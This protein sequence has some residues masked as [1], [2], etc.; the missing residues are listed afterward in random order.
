MAY[1]DFGS[2]A[3]ILVL[4]LVAAHVLGHVFMRLHQPRVI[5]EITAGI[6][7]GPYILGNLAPALSHAIFVPGGSHDAVLEFLSMLGLLLLM[8]LSGVEARNLFSRHD[9]REIAW[10]A[11]VGTS[12]P[13]LLALVAAPYIPLEHVAGHNGKG[14][15]LVL[16]FG[17]AV[18]VTSIPVLSRIFHDLGVLHTR[19]ARLVLG[20][21]VIEDILLW[22]VLSIAT[23]LATSAALSERELV[24][25]VGAT[26][27]YF[28]FGLT[29]AVPLLQRLGAARWNVLAAASPVGYVTAV[30]LAYAAVAAVFDVSFVFAAFL[31]G[32]AMADQ[33]SRFGEA[34][35]AL[36][37]LSF[38]VFIPI[39]FAM[40][41]YQLHLG[42]GFSATL[43][44]VF[45]LGTCTV[46]L[47]SVGLGARLAGFAGMDIVNLAV[48]TNARG[49]PGIVLASVA[50]DAGIINGAFYTTLV[51]VALLTSQVAG[52]W[53]AFVLRRGWPLLTPRPAETAEPVVAPTDIAADPR[54][55]ERPPS[56]PF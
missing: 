52:A 23:A 48:A 46:K 14:S 35:D 43:L 36:R 19:F 55:G 7:L 2:L 5:G 44:V 53:L 12:L 25:H 11:S 34:L 40:V 24:V 38:A 20:M 56:R 39:Y 4:L 13:F 49:G 9:R 31:A 21:A 22:A 33:G 17:I 32:F 54:P 6:L 1:R 3:L 10:L 28:G 16:V 45:L 29:I 47:L 26:V 30:P 18:A 51:L 41:G 50:L 42:N 8:F 15:A 37:K 27:V